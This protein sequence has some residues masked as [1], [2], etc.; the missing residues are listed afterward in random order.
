MECS[1]CYSVKDH[2]IKC[3]E[4]GYQTCHSCVQTYLLNITSDAHCMNCRC[5]WDILFLRKNLAMEFLN[6]VFRKRRM[7]L[8]KRRSHRI[9]MDTKEMICPCPSCLSGKI[10]KSTMSCSS[11]WMRLCR[12]CFSP[13]QSENQHVCQKEIISSL[14]LIQQTTKKCPSCHVPI[15]KKSGCFQM[16]CTYCYTA[17]DWDKTLILEKN[18]HNPHYFDYCFQSQQLRVSLEKKL[19]HMSDPLLKKKYIEFYYLFHDIKNQL[20]IYSQPSSSITVDLYEKDLIHQQHQCQYRIWSGFYKRAF[21]LL[22]QIIN[23]TSSSLY[24]QIHSFQNDLKEQLIDY[25]EHVAECLQLRGYRL[26]EC[27]PPTSCLV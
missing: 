8:L 23:S 26:F 1:V 12:D 18:I 20:Q 13:I 3:V 14:Q 10:I 25:N 6:G 11:C 21:Q 5:L 15:E 27:N 9:H 4:C 7:E 19:T 16:F 22:Q 17:F 24:Q 2:P